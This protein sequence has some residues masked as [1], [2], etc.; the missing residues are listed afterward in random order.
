MTSPAAKMCG[1]S[2]RNCVSTCKWPRLPAV[3]PATLRFKPSVAP[4]RP[5][6]YKTDSETTRFPDSQGQYHASWRP[7]D[8]VY[9]FYGLAEA[10]RHMTVS[11]LMD[12]LF[13]D[14]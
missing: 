12:E 2:V 4:I 9:A 1:T 13:H 8:H 10:E 6:A 3:K 7:V 5:A 11:H 14:F